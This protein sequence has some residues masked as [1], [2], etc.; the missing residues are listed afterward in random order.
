MLQRSLLLLWLVVLAG[1]GAVSQ[2][3]PPVA[4]LATA[5]PAPTALPPAP[6]AVPSPAPAAELAPTTLAP[7]PTTAPVP[8]ASLRL[9][10]TPL[11]EGFTRPVHVTSA[12]DGSARLFVVEQAGRIWIV[13]DGQ[14]I[15]PV[16]LDLTD[17]VGSSGNEQGLL[18]IAFHPQFVANGRFFVNYTDRNGNTVVA[19]YRV[20]AAQ[21]DRADRTSATT[22]L[23]IAQPASNHNGGLLKF[24]PDGMLYIGTGD[25]GRA[26]DPWNNAQNL[27]SL[28]GKLLRIDV[29]GDQPYAVP[30]DNPLRDQ[31][32][33]RP[34]IW[35]YGLRNPWRFAFDRLTGDLYLA[36]VGQNALEEVHFQPATS[37][38]GENYGWKIMEGTACYEP[39]NC[40]PTGL[41]LPVAVYGRDGGCSITG[42]YVYRGERY[43]QLNGVYLYSDFCTGN[44]WALRAEAGAWQNALVGR[45]AIQPSSFGEDE[46]GELLIA[47]RDGGGI[48]RLTVSEPVGWLPTIMC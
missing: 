36:D 12:G 25:G 18:S 42:G 32:G 17:R 21:P 11:I 14:R 8:L 24:G 13:R 15:E 9:G 30:A 33:A 19:Q 47:D 27:D 6:S 46:A 26:G 44:L 23:T 1:C 35:A 31:A 40:D 10:I 4:P 3:P 45:V 20:D 41:E 16:F 28:L 43:P 29:D 7:A 48:Y 2:T 34:E 5:L 37:P 38:G 39:Q 22:I